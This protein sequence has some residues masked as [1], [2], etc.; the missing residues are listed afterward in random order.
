MGRDSASFS[1][2]RSCFRRHFASSC[3]SFFFRSVSFVCVFVC[4]C[5]FFFPF[6]FSYFTFLKLSFDYFLLPNF[7]FS[8]NS[9]IYLFIYLLFPSSHIH[10]IIFFFYFFLSS[11]YFRLLSPSAFTNLFSCHF[12]QFLISSSYPSSNSISLSCTPFPSTYQFSRL[13]IHLTL[14][15]VFLSFI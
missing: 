9:V 7:S 5:G 15:F 12:I 2:N 14:S 4:V 11:S 13:L 1:D 8:Y 6:F 10:R 3:F